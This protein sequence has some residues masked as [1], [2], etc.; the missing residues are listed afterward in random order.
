MLSGLDVRKEK[1]RVTVRAGTCKEINIHYVTYVPCTYVVHMPQWHP[2]NHTLYH[3]P[4]GVQSFTALR[5]HIIARWG[6][7]IMLVTAYPVVRSKP[8]RGPYTITGPF[9]GF[10]VG[11]MCLGGG[12]DPPV[13]H[14]RWC[15][16]EQFWQGI[17]LGCLSSSS[18]SKGIKWHAAIGIPQ[19]WSSIVGQSA[20]TALGD[21]TGACNGGPGQQH[22][23]ERGGNGDGRQRH[24]Q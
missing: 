4:R 22:Q 24:G 10:G 19:T 14:L 1:F 23:Q 15:P 16:V 20:E 9:V 21:K 7:W 2:V 3:R 18:A 11:W 13:I 12:R 17:L 8:E 5:W 6:N